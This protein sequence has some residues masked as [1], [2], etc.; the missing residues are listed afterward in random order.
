MEIEAKEEFTNRLREVISPFIYDGI[1]AIW[2]LSKNEALHPDQKRKI[3][4]IFQTKLSHIPFWNQIII[5]SEYEKI[6]GNNHL[7]KL[8]EAVFISYVHILSII[9]TRKLSK[10]NVKVPETKNFIH[11]CYI[12]CARRFYLEPFLFDNRTDKV[13]YNQMQKN[14]RKSIE[15]IRDS[16]T[17]TIR[18]SLPMN[19]ILIESIRQQKEDDENSDSESEKPTENFTDD[20]KSEVNSIASDHIDEQP[21]ETDLEYNRNEN[22]FMRPPEPIE[23]NFNVIGGNSIEDMTENLNTKNRDDSNDYKDFFPEDQ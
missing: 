14:Y 19:D 20:H 21:N 23:T 16:I 9:R 6:K 12:E 1:Q 15:L 4:I 11:Q 17:S 18:S 8:I 3:F 22:E 2:E 10:L 13:D 5:D 7:D